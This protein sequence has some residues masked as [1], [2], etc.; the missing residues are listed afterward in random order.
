[1]GQ[2]EFTRSSIHGMKSI[3]RKNAK[4]K[5]KYLIHFKNSEIRT[6]KKRGGRRGKKVAHD[7]WFPA[8]AVCKLLR[9]VF[10]SA[11]SNFG[12]LVP[13]FL[14]DTFSDRF[15]SLTM[16]SSSIPSSISSSSIPSSTIMSNR[17][18]CPGSRSGP[19]G[20]STAS[21][22]SS[23]G[24]SS[25]KGS[26][27]KH[28]KVVEEEDEPEEEEIALSDEDEQEDANDYVKGGYHPVKI[29]DVFENRYSLSFIIFVLNYLSI[30]ITIFF[31]YCLSTSSK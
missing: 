16:I 31:N 2:F 26:F 27:G 4:K 19:G 21:G 24:Q 10:R 1:M 22:Y 5:M 18:K 17:E 14:V 23:S 28:G 29:G 11:L 30:L 12:I 25:G 20:S 15:H 7:F 13:S 9:T 8:R 3:W 6:L